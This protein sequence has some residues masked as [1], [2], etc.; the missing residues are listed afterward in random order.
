MRAEEG[1]IEGK[2]MK[3]AKGEGLS[4]LT[5]TTNY[6]TCSSLLKPIAVPT[7]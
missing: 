6:L 7:T 3:Q 1:F 2:G 5:D 4:G